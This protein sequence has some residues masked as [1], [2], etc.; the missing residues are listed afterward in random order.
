MALHHA[1]ARQRR[2]GQMAVGVL[3]FGDP[4]GVG[5]GLQRRRRACRAPGARSAAQSCSW[6]AG[7]PLAWV[8]ICGHRIAGGGGTPSGIGVPSCHEQLEAM[9]SAVAPITATARSQR[10]GDTGL[11]QTHSDRCPSSHAIR[12]LGPSAGVAQGSGR[13]AGSQISDA[14]VGGGDKQG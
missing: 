7:L 4:G 14:D 11:P 6:S 5:V 1:D 12:E 3:H 2:P 13:S 9:S 10:T 8:S